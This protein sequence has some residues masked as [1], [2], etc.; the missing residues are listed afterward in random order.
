MCIQNDLDILLSINAGGMARRGE[1][2][3]LF[4]EYNYGDIRVIDNINGKFC[5]ECDVVDPETNNVCP[6]LRI[7]ANERRLHIIAEAVDE[8]TEDELI[9]MCPT[10]PLLIYL[11]ELQSKKG[12]RSK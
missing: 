5:I 11:M 4:G 1:K 3:D 2:S 10:P 8:C 6:F 9:A 7:E 12:K